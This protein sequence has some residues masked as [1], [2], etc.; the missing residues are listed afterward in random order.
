MAKITI[1]YAVLLILIGIS[2]YVGTGRTSFTA[3]IPAFF[4]IPILVCGLLALKD[5]Y[6][7]HAM[8]AAVALGLLAFIGSAIRALPGLPELIQGVSERPS[9][10]IAQ[11]LMAVLSLVFVILGVKNFV[12]VRRARRRA[13][14]T[15]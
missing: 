4:G 15:A 12:D 5:S 2:F 14:M 10:I 9:A 11:L 13:A 3:L 7:K 1:G 6:R 8:H